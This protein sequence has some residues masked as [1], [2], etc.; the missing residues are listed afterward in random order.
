MF[1]RCAKRDS[2]RERGGKKKKS[3]FFSSSLNYDD[4]KCPVVHI[5]AHT[6]SSIYSHL[7]KISHYIGI[8]PVICHRLL[9]FFLSLA[10]AL[11]LLLF[12]SYSNCSTVAVQNSLRPALVGDYSKH[13]NTRAHTHTLMLL[14]FAAP[15]FL[16]VAFSTF[17]LR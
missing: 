14:F 7:Q 2:E 17:K 3:I 8:L 4:I 13:F 9:L 1:S 6:Y 5:H 11:F 16:F 12:H 15:I 10:R